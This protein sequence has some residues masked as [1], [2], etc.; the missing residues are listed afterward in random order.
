MK[1]KL[2]RSIGSLALILC[3]VLMF[4]TAS[5]MAISL[6]M[7]LSGVYVEWGPWNYS[8][9]V[10]GNFYNN[11]ATE[12]EL[13]AAELWN[14]NWVD[15]FCV[16]SDFV[17]PKDKQPVPQNGEAPYRLVDA[18]GFLKNEIPIKMADL[19]FFGHKPYSQRDTQ[20]AIWQYL[21]V[22]TNTSDDLHAKA[23]KAWELWNAAVTTPDRF[24]AYILKGEWAVADHP[25]YQAFLTPVPEPGTILL[26]GAGLI[27]L[28]G[29]R[30]FRKK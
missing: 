15:V 16:S 6:P 10:G 22:V 17:P 25:K 29:F 18:K 24:D 2:L 30:R 8:G 13:K 20:I 12:Y 1:R 9:T 5:S 7:E 14:G 4:G 27:G 28:I 21:G 26:L 11:I 3:A 19:Y 23:P